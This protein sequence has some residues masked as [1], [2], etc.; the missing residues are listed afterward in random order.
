[1][2]ARQFVTDHPVDPDTHL[3]VLG[4]PMSKDAA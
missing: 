3:F 2:G 1:M 4:F